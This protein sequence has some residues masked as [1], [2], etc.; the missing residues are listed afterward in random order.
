ML[1]WYNKMLIVI[2]FSKIVSLIKKN[3]CPMSPHSPNLSLSTLSSWCEKSWFLQVFP[4]FAEAATI[5]AN[6]LLADPSPQLKPGSQ[7]QQNLL[8]SSNSPAILYHKISAILVVWQ[9]FVRLSSCWCKTL[10]SH[11]SYSRLPRSSVLLVL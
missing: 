8:S 11:F 3:V 1:Y 9:H 4:L 10:Y 7:K 2:C 6:S 5:L